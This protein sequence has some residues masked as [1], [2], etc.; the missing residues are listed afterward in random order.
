MSP[1]SIMIALSMTANGEAGD[2]K[3]EMESILAYGMIDKILDSH[4]ENTVGFL[5]PYNN[6]EYSFL[7]LIPNEDIDIY[8]Y[9][10]GF[11]YE[12]YVPLMENKKYCKED[13]TIPKFSSEYESSLIDI[14]KDMG[15]KKCFEYAYGTKASAATKVDMVKSYI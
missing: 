7:D 15:I 9:I 3:T 5:K 10:E 4:T 11:S 13:A 8:D 1:L 12:K 2:T 14:L 6:N